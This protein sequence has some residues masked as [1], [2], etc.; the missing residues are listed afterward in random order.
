M[1]WVAMVWGSDRDTC[2]DEGLPRSAGMRILGGEAAATD[3]VG[4]GNLTFDTAARG[5]RELRTNRSQ[6]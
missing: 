2:L 4:V 5:F 6:M 3:V 1:Y